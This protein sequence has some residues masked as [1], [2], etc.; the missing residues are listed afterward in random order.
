MVNFFS[1]KNKKPYN[2]CDVCNKKVPISYLAFI[3]SCKCDKHLCSKHKFPEDHKCTY[4]Y[5]SEQKEKLEKDLPLVVAD[6]VP[7]RI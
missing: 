4:D 3:R 7:N 2:R 1:K 5:K 6:K